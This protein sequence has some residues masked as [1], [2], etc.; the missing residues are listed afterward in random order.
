M[1]LLPLRIICFGR[2][3]P[4]R[5]ATAIALTRIAVFVGFH[6][7]EC[8]PSASQTAREEASDAL[9]IGGPPRLSLGGIDDAGRLFE[10]FLLLLIGG[11]ERPWL[12]SDRLASAS[13]ARCGARRPKTVSR[14]ELVA[15]G[16]MKTRKAASTIIWCLLARRTLHPQRRAT[17]WLSQVMV[18]SGFSSLLLHPCRAAASM[19]EPSAVPPKARPA[20]RCRGQLPSPPPRAR[21]ISAIRL[22]IRWPFNA[23]CA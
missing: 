18:L 1:E 14:P 4:L 21:A 15:A 22:R 9:A 6:A 19:V 5:T 12:P 11:P 8:L 17:G 10:N 16:S 7:T 2:T 13:S 3:H 20:P 23:L